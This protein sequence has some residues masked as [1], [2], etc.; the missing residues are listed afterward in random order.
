M[1]G[2]AQGWFANNPA[3]K[4]TPQAA[5]PLHAYYA[6]KNEL[7]KLSE[8]NKSFRLTLAD[9]LLAKEKLDAALK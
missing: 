7:S 6:G 9:S 1:L 4:T 5:S 2:L 8:Q 3:A